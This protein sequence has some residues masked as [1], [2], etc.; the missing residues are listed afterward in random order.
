MATLSEAGKARVVVPTN[1]GDY[2]L[3]ASPKED[4][5]VFATVV[6]SCP[7]HCCCCSGVWHQGCCASS[8]H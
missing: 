3:A 8:V 6:E 5:A 1:F 4:V 2:P 7:G